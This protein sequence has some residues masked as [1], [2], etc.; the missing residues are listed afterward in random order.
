MR[1]RVASPCSADWNAMQGDARVRFC[2]Q[3]EKNVYNLSAMTHAQAEDLIREKE[4]GLCVRFYQRADGTVLTADCPV[5]KRRRRRRSMLLT[6]GAAGLLVTA[7]G[8]LAFTQMG[9]PSKFVTGAL[10]RVIEEPRPAIA[11]PEH[12]TMGTPMP[13]PP[14]EQTPSS[15]KAR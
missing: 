15:H 8:F 4:G 10:P 2:G 11:P 7:T 12:A 9:R 13:T 3:C 14:T 6:A 5:G 1:L